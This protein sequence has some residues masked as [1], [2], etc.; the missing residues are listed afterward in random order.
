MHS[1]YRS[2]GL[3]RGNVWRSCTA[4]CRFAWFTALITA[5]FAVGG[6][7]NGRNVWALTASCQD[8]W[9]A[10]VH[11]RDPETVS[12]GAVS[13]RPGRSSSIVGRYLIVVLGSEQVE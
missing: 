13:S 2:K 4:N 9:T 12:K 6:R 10:C 3:D 5:V 8:W 1:D 7:A 11:I